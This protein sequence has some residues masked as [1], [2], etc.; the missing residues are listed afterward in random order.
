MD[1]AATA[2][3]PACPEADCPASGVQVAFLL[4]ISLLVVYL[5]VCFLGGH[6]D[7]RENFVSKKAR[8]V[9]DR[10]REVFEE[11]GGDANYSKYKNRVPGADPVQ[12]ADVRRL[13]REGKLSPHNVEDVL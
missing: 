6:R 10:A 11:G 3:C 5:V 12:Y 9:H 1:T 13:F 4:V 7:K 2:G 8:E